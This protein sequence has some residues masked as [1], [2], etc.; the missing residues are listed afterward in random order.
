M[1][2]KIETIQADKI[3]MRGFR[4]NI[5]PYGPDH[6]VIDICPFTSATDC[7]THG[8]VIGW[9]ATTPE[10]APLASEYHRQGLDW[11]SYTRRILSVPAGLSWQGISAYRYLFSAD[12]YDS[13]GFTCAGQKVEIIRRLQETEAAL[14]ENGERPELI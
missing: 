12:Q 14:K 4:A 1:R 3:Y 5:R 2:K 8:C 10:L 9:A 11:P 13:L 6:E 7:G